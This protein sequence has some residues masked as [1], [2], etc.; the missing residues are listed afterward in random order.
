MTT[1]YVLIKREV[2]QS[3][4]DALVALEEW[5]YATDVHCKPTIS[6][7]QAVLAAPCE[8]VK[9]TE[10]H[11]QYIERYNGRCRD[12]ADE[13]GVCPSSGLPC[14]NSKKAV[15]SVLDALSYGV[16]NNYLPS[17]YALK[18]QDDIQTT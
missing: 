11:I 8:P 17:L 16:N 13:N 1:E 14:E 7:L 3:A 18:D 4:T 9:F 10:Q 15:K 6:E 12:C 2:L 5:H